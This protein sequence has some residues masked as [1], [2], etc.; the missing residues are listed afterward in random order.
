[1]LYFL[2][3]QFWIF[4]LRVYRFLHFLYFWFHH[5]EPFHMFRILDFILLSNTYF[6]AQ[7]VEQLAVRRVFLNLGRYFGPIYKVFLYFRK[8]V[9]ADTIWKVHNEVEIEGISVRQP[10]VVFVYL[11]KVAIS[12]DISFEI[13]KKFVI[14][15][16][17]AL[18]FF[19]HIYFGLFWFIIELGVRK[20]WVVFQFDQ[21]PKD[22]KFW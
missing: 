16:V 22:V 3:I 17:E 21:I 14:F 10:L 11:G 4:D 20:K 9:K 12:L 18:D 1:M 2:T 6:Q 5:P 7:I 13:S 8:V 15:W 19:G